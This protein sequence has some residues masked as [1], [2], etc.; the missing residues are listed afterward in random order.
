AAF[1]PAEPDRAGAGDAALACPRRLPRAHGKRT[2]DP[3]RQP[4]RLRTPSRR[5]ADCGVN[6]GNIPL[7]RH[8]VTVS[9]ASRS[10][11]PYLIPIGA[12]FL[13]AEPDRA[14]AG[15]AALACPRRL[16]RAHG[17]RTLAPRRQPRRLRPP[18]RRWADCG[19]N[20]GNIPLDR[21][22]VTV[23]NASRSKRPYLI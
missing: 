9:N 3:R 6:L 1:L 20:L 17:K 15:D 16:P 14:G 12:A 2:L 11:R 5:W 10:K 7:D 22:Y 23:S 19:V 18:S 8:Y 21:H 4:R 13:P